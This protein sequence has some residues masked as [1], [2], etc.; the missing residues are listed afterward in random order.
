MTSF[1]IAAYRSAAECSQQGKASLVLL[2]YEAVVRFVREARCGAE[3]NDPR[4][5]GER[6]SDAMAIITELDAALD[7]EIGGEIAESLNSLY[8]WIMNHLTR[9]N[10][11]N[12][13]KALDDVLNVLTELKEGFEGA[14]AQELGKKDPQ[15]PNQQTEKTE[16]VTNVKVPSSRRLSVAI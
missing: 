16:K 8:A 9:A 13:I 11:H 4:I 15:T 5:R 10:L 3:V 7:Y 1:G 6:I 12:D 14:A 2:A